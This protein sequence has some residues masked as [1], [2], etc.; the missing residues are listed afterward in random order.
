MRAW[1]VVLGAPL[2]S[3]RYRHH[4]EVVGETTVCTGGSWWVS[5][6]Q[7]VVGGDHD[8]QEIILDLAIPEARYLRDRLTKLIEEAETKERERV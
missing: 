5:L 3:V 1:R 7:F 8:G 6:R 4:Y 2:G